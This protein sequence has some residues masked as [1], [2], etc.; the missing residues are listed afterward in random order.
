MSGIANTHVLNFP[1]C[2]ERFTGGHSLPNFKLYHWAFTLCPLVSSY[3]DK[4]YV[5][6]RALEENLVLPLKLDEILFANIPLNKCK[7]HFGPLVSHV[8]SVWRAAEKVCDI[9]S[10]RNPYSPIFNNEGL[11]IG[12]HPIKSGQCRQWYNK[13]IHSL[14]DI[15]GNKGLYT[16]WTTFH[17]I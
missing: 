11:L 10:N 1:W 17:S 5:S 12:N 7:L 2:N 13:G 14:G 6:W 3:N 9:R 16:F 15:M 4:I 8:L